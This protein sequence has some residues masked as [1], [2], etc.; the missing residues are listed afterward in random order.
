MPLLLLLLAGWL[1]RR[2]VGVL[3]QLLLVMVLVCER[4]RVA[5]C[6]RLAP[7]STRGAVFYR[8]CTSSN[9]TTSSGRV[10]GRGL[11]HDQCGCARRGGAAVR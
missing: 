7:L 8:Q 4:E 6:G 10:I 9:N 5:G 2:V 3:L 11:P 1:A